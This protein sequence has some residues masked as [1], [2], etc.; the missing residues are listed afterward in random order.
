MNILLAQLM[1]VAELVAQV[2][3]N[4]GGGGGGD[5]GAGAAGAIGNICIL[6]FE[7]AYAALMI[8]SMWG[9]FTKAGEPGWAAIVPVYNI[10]I[11][12]KICD[13]PVWWVIFFFCPCVNIIFSILVAIELAN[14]FGQGGGFAVGLIL[15]PFV[16]YPMLAWGSYKYIPPQTAGGGYY[17]DDRPR[18]RREAEEDDEDRPRRP[19]PRDEDDDDR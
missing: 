11:L 2:R 4:Q 5:G 3:Q 17:D 6:V 1:P 8:A 15:L 9:I 12:L 16:F 14:R 19:R 10:I 7:L 13:K 18:R